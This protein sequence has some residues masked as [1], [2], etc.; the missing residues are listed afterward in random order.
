MTIAE[1]LALGIE[2]SGGILELK[3]DGRICYEIPKGAE[4]L[5][6]LLR[7]HKA[8]IVTLLRLRSSWPAPLSHAEHYCRMR[9]AGLTAC[10]REEWEHKH[11]SD[12]ARMA[13]YERMCRS[14]ASGEVVQ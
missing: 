5:L 4:H 12:S 14:G 13:R 2:R 7:E 9:A 10:G 11:G 3:G 8:E 1:Q 6:P